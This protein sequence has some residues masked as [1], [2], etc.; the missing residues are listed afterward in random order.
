MSRS[1]RQL[2]KKDLVGP[3]RGLAQIEERHGN[4]ESLTIRNTTVDAKLHLALLM[5]CA[6]ARDEALS[7]VLTEISRLM[8]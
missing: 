4:W 1:K 8:H 6:N 7:V 5:A 3:W 2:I